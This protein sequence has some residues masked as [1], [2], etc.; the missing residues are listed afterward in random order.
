MNLPAENLQRRYSSTRY[1]AWRRRREILKRIRSH[2]RN[3][4]DILENWARKTSLE[5]VILAKN[6]RYAVAREDLTVLMNSLRKIES[7]DHRVRITI[8]RY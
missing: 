4:K 6:L 7:E 1:P 8:T 2:H 5:I 3:A